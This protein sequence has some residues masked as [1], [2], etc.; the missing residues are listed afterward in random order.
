MRVNAKPTA[1]N[2]IADGNAISEEMGIHDRIR[3]SSAMYP[4]IVA[5]AVPITK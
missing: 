2:A 3:A 5:M 4:R 1:A